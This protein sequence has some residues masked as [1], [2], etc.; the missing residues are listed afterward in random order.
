MMVTGYWLLV[1]GWWIQVEYILEFMVLKS[2]SEPEPVIEPG[3][4]N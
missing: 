2:V 4:S 1:I 3:S